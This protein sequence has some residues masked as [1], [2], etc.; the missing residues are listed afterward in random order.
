MTR[1][2]IAKYR[3]VLTSEHITHLIEL[4]KTEGSRLSLKCIS[5]LAPFEH[6]IKNGSV[7]AAYSSE[8]KISSSESF[9]FETDANVRSYGAQTMA[10]LLQLWN[11]SPTLL[12]AEDLKKVQEFRYTNNL[13]SEEQAAKYESDLIGI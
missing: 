6:K 13:M 1:P 3:P 12:N 11:K 10:E 8:P 9:G 2:N 5:V 4:C 7:S